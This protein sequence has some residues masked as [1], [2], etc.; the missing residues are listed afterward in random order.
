MPKTI[1]GTA[2]VK[3]SVEAPQLQ[4]ICEF[5]PTQSTEDSFVTKKLKNMTSMLYL[6]PHSPTKLLNS[7]TVPRSNLAPNHP[8]HHNFPHTINLSIFNQRPLIIH[9]SVCLHFHHSP[10]LLFKLTINHNN[11]LY[12]KYLQF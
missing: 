3:N 7:P 2:L 11:S 6:I 9:T 8:N 10:F 12:S 4:V 5:T 1:H